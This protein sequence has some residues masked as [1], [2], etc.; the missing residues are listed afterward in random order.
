MRVSDAAKF[1]RWAAL[2]CLSSFRTGIP[3]FLH[4]WQIYFLVYIYGRREKRSRYLAIR[5]S[6]KR[7]RRVSLAIVRLTS[8]IYLVNLSNSSQNVSA[9]IENNLKLTK[10]CRTLKNLSIL[11][12]EIIKILSGHISKNRYI[13][14]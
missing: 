10:S 1:R 2:L 13:I 3:G 6:E 5:W 7:F 12:A 14:N 11:I 9:N 4:S 8:F